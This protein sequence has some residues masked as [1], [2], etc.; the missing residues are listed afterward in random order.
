LR[1][2]VPSQNCSSDHAGNWRVDEY[3]AVEDPHVVRPT[4]FANS[5]L[6]VLGVLLVVERLMRTPSKRII[7]EGS[8]TE[9]PGRKAIW[10]IISGPV[11]EGNCEAE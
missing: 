10:V 11:D 4:L 8:L 1:H 9:P 7:K 2:R 5:V 3:K 6:K